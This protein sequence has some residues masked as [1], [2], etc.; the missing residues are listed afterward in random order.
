MSFQSNHLLISDVAKQFALSEAT[1]AQWIV[2]GALM[3]QRNQNEDP[4]ILSDSV[5][6]I[7]EE[8]KNIPIIDP[9]ASDVIKVAI[10]EDDSDLCKLLEMTIHN[11]DF[12]TQIQTATNGLKGLA[13][14][15]EYKPDILI[16]DLNM[17]VMDGFRL[18]QAIDGTELAPK[19]I[20]VITALDQNIISSRGG[21][22]SNATIISKPFNLSELEAQFRAWFAHYPVNLT[23]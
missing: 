9:V 23:D 18:L 6:G 1:I 11:F 4:L 7:L 16:A 12:K 10:V 17:P 19:K 8:K 21:L 13:L 20:V 15:T 5:N 3:V 2:A 22:P 14:L